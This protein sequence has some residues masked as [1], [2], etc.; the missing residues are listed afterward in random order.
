MIRLCE[1]GE[2]VDRWPRSA[3]LRT[4][5]AG[6]VVALTVALEPSASD[7]MGRLPPVD[8]AVLYSVG[9]CI[10][11]VFTTVWGGPSGQRYFITDRKGVT[12]EILL[13][14]AVA[15][16]V[17][18]PLALDRRRVTVRGRMESTGMLTATRVELGESE[19]RHED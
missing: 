18:G 3:R 2:T 6:A 7:I 4:I 8:A 13:D 14:A 10:E 12:T 16:P 19:C 1:I 11:G 15:R 17:G 5:C 9:A